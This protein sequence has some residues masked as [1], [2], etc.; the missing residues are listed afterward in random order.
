[1]IALASLT[2]TQT[3]LASTEKQISTGYRVAD[4]TD[5]GAAFA[6]AQGIRSS[7]G[8]LTS[9]NQ[10]LG[11]AQGL[12]SVTVSS[13]SDISN[14]L[15]SARD[16]LVKLGDSN[17]QGTQRSQYVTQYKSLLQNVKSDIEGADYNGKT[18][19]G[20]ITGSE[21]AASSGT[22]N[23]GIAVVKDESGD[24]YGVGSYSGSALFAALSYNSS[25]SLNRSTFAQSAIA[26]S[27]SFITQLNKLGTQLNTYGSNQN[28]I[29]NQINYNTDKINSLNS[30][31]GVLVD[32]NLAVESANLQSLQT[33]QSLGTQ[34]LSL[35]NSA[36]SSLL[37]LFR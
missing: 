23:S 1:M 37:S 4:A 35:A 31:L 3:Q 28:Y 12:V 18:L 15:N 9:S 33:Q 34:A 20:D 6:V 22:L 24:T 32:A 21:G 17:T 27:G 2:H 5:D 26:T 29:T 19:I 16:V 36:P 30:G 10:Q 25:T 7:V 13:L 11:N 8:A 14:L